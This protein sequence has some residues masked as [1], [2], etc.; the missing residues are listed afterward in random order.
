[1][2]IIYRINKIEQLFSTF[3]YSLLHY[4]YKIKEIYIVYSKESRKLSS[5]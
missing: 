4:N 1:M 5:D 2:E 3:K